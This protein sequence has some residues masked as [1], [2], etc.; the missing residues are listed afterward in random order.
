MRK[1]LIS[2]LRENHSKIQQDPDLVEKIRKFV[3][4]PGFMESKKYIS[5]GFMFDNIFL[6]VDK[7]PLHIHAYDTIMTNA[8]AIDH[9]SRE[10]A[11]LSP[12]LLKLI[13]KNKHIGTLTEDVSANGKFKIDDRGIIYGPY[14]EYNF[15]NWF[16]PTMDLSRSVFIVTEKDDFSKEQKRNSSSLIRLPIIDLDHIT[17]KSEYLKLFGGLADAKFK[18]E[19]LELVLD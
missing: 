3:L 8:L 19:E 17:L 14:E 11:D 4:E 15:E 9:F 7:I 10:R 13:F 16:E 6:G 5:T 18:P 12:I 2:N 1:N